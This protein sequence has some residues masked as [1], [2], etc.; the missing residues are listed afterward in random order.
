MKRLSMFTGMMSVALLI[1]ACGDG[2]ADEG[3][4]EDTGETAGGEEVCGSEIAGTI[5]SD[6]IWA[7]DHTLTSIVT[8][9]NGATLTIEPGVTIKGGNGT[10][11]VIGKGSQLFA[12]G[13]AD[14]PIV[15]T[16]A[17]PEG[18]R[19]RG[20]W[21]GLV[22]LGLA[23]NNLQTGTG[24]AEGLDANDPTYQYGGMDEAS[25]CGSLKYLRVEFA[26]FELTKDNELNGITFYSCGTGTRVDYV[27]SHMG[28]DDGI[29][30]FGGN[31]SGK[32]IVITGALDDA[33]DADQGYTGSLQYVFI[34]QD[35][36]TGNYGFEWS[37][38]KDNLDAIPRTRPVVS[39]L[40]FIGT[41]TD[42]DNLV[43]TK[44]SAVKLKEGTGAEIHNAILMYSYNA[45]IELTEEATELVADAGDIA[46]TDT[47]L[48][49]NS[50]ADDGASP[51][52]GSDG[53]SWD[54]PGFIEDAANRNHI[55]VDPKLGSV[56]WGAVDIAP[57]VDSPALGNGRPVAGAEATDYIGAVK[58][59]SSD[60]TKGWTNYAPN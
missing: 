51:Y 49:M 24:A 38:Q 37:N 42:P 41:A 21:G 57:A 39:N 47:I 50:R 19:A 56:A 27:Q 54:L 9:K 11:L 26:G 55:D 35:P 36:A 23:P 16:S 7:C 29:E 10:A 45:G 20:D 4:D 15:L 60:W 28:A 13:T 1:N 40:T 6:T 58:D 22:L 30:A 43:M 48:F 17:L 14:K 25:S 46:L 52:K 44:S 2:T 33:F 3:S 31:W 8:V 12:E 59:A 34:H 18:S 32:H 5:E 53:S